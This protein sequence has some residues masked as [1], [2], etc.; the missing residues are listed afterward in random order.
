MMLETPQ[1]FI[2]R[3]ECEKAAWQHGYRRVLGEIDGWAA[4]ESTTAQGILW[5]AAASEQGPW[6]VAINHLGVIAELALPSANI[7]GPGIERYAFPTLAALYAILPRLYQLAASLPDVPLKSF[8]H[9]TANLPKTTEAERLVVQRIGQNIFRDSLIDYW[10]GRCPL[11]GIDDSALLRASHIIPWSE[12]ETDAQRLDVHNGL[13]LSA[14]WDAAFDRALVTFKDNG[15]P[16]FSKSLSNATREALKWSKPIPL[17]D[18]HRSHLLDHRQRFQAAELET[19]STESANTVTS[20]DDRNDPIIWQ[21]ACARLLNSIRVIEIGITNATDL[22]KSD[23]CLT[24]IVLA[25]FAFENAFKA[26]V[27]RDGYA[28]YKDENLQGFRSHAYM[29]WAE[30][31]GIIFDGSEREALDKAQF[32]CAA[33]GRYPCHNKRNKERPIESWAWNDVNQIKNL[34]SRLSD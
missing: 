22:E 4:F 6:Y 18:Q 10:Q 5:L 3:E 30:E 19:S 1:P 32:F 23:A 31:W 17:T 24:A 16:V 26:K 9:Q 11:T 33:W 29:Q 20:L 28:L 2:V 27:L 8:H 21:A 15:T 7:A 34:I 12:C 13:L 25:G 14:L